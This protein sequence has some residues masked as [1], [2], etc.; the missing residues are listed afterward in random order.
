METSPQ[1][2]PSR[3]K[4]AS[5]FSFQPVNDGLGFHP[6]EDGL[7]YTPA[8]TKKIAQESVS[9]AQ[10]NSAPGK[11][12]LTNRLQRA[13]Q[14]DPS[15]G[16]KPAALGRSQVN[17]TPAPVVQPT[18]P[19]EAGTQ[20]LDEALR[21]IA[22][23]TSTPVS[24]EPQ[25]IATSPAP[26]LNLEIPI[27]EAPIVQKSFPTETPVKPAIAS[28]ELATAP[29]IAPHSRLILAGLMDLSLHTTLAILTVGTL[30][31]IEKTPRSLML[32]TEVITLCVGF[33]L[34]FHWALTAAQ[35]VAFGATIGKRALGIELSGNASRVFMRS[36]LSLP[37]LALAGLGC[38]A[39]IPDRISGVFPTIVE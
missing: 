36:I 22:A 20:K 38:L 13:L 28:P 9:A 10:T 12:I 26:E 7:P 2:D 18:A 17:P 3:D 11:A 39:R 5:D 4:K 23:A 33:V 14:F 31:W 32:E 27:S 37:C 6:F 34:L 19:S 35:E 15:G 30:L 16:K 8:T 1:L 24:H 25:F 21:K 29:R